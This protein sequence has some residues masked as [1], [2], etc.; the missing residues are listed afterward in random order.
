VRLFRIEAG[1]ELLLDVRGE[2]TF[3]GVAH[4]LEQTPASCHVEALEDSFLVRIERKSFARTLEQHP[5]TAAFFRVNFTGHF[6]TRVFQELRKRGSPPPREGFYLFSM[7]VGDVV[8]GP[9]AVIERGLNLRQAADHMVRQRVG[10]LL[11]REQSQ[12]I[13]G[14]VTDKDLR[15]ALASGLSIDAAVETIMSAPVECVDAADSCFDALLHM[16]GLDIR[17]VAVRREGTIVGVVTAHDILL[18]HGR[19][20]LSVFRQIR[21]Q[22]RFEGLYAIADALPAMT[23][24]LLDDGAT[25]VTIT[26]ILAVA[27]DLLIGRLLEL[28]HLR[29]GP[30]P[31]PYCW[32]VLGE[33]GRGEQ[34]FCSESQQAVIYADH[35]DD[36]LSQ[37]AHSY[38]AAIAGKMAEHLDRCGFCNA[39]G[40]LDP[41]H[42][43]NQ[44]SLKGWKARFD[45]WLLRTGADAAR[46]AP[47][48]DFRPAHGQRSLAEALRAHLTAACHSHGPLLKTL[49][50]RALAEALPLS[51]FN[52]H[53]V[54]RSG[55]RTSELDIRA[56]ALA[57][58]VD[59]IRTLALNAGISDTG[60]LARL[61]RLAAAGLLPETLARDTADAFTCLH[62]L[63]LVHRLEDIENC[64]PPGD[65]I[66][67]ADLS[68]LER[69]ALKK[70]FRT[71][72]DLR[73]CLART[74]DR[75]SLRGQAQ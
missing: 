58:C 40:L 54:E 18:A 70:A 3:F 68:P 7:Q 36:I 37:A 42:A 60:T 43:R 65:R 31:L 28:L 45:D 41:A 55:E 10:S 1:Q 23:R 47:F 11:I 38:F 72:E 13:I 49:G 39:G 48:F 27:V 73:V 2:D 59:M 62:H 56:R 61:A 66:R 53:L 29:Y 50:Q 30:P 44:R 64:R 4:A 32:I 33:A 8:A 14:I 34:L 21:R 74:L 12:E 5:E 22:D 20:P 57:P 16:T 69:G 46:C 25:A 15:R 52:G 24:T 63:R 19:T 67:P 26:R 75:D 17:H 9:P 51:F 71:L 6:V 35:D